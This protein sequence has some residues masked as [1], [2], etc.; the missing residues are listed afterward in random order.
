[1]DASTPLTAT[2]QFIQAGNVDLILFFLFSPGYLKM[3]TTT[4]MRIPSP[5]TRTPT[6]YLPYPT[7]ARD[8]LPNS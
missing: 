8:A 1:M 2:S 4:W 7:R 3:T 6:Q 5:D